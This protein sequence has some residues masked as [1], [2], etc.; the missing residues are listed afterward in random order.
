M[1]R[2]L[3]IIGFK[4][5]ANNMDSQRLRWF[6]KSIV[7]IAIASMGS[8]SLNAID[9]R[10]LMRGVPV[11]KLAKSAGLAIGAFG[12]EYLAEKCGQKLQGLSKRL[13]DGNEKSYD[14]TLKKCLQG[15]ILGCRVVAMGA[16]G[17]S[18]YKLIPSAFTQSGDSI[19]KAA[20]QGL[21]Q[22]LAAA[23]CFKKIH[24]RIQKGR[25]EAKEAKDNSQQ[26]SFFSRAVG[27]G[28][29]A[30]GFLASGL[31]LKNAYQCIKLAH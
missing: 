30:G 23:L 5:R 28:Y 17:C 16:I 24:D 26:P 21:G 22:G 27:L 31:S 11:S 13:N 15:A 20:V 29:V 7:I 2:K 14:K 18:L 25:K 19:G 8:S 9:F 1:K 6:S 12:A 3:C 10:G 4:E